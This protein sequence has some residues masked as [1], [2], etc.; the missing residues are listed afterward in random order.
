MQ[1]GDGIGR[2]SDVDEFFFSSRRRHTR[3]TGD[4]SS[5]VC[6]SDLLILLAAAA[7]LA[8]ELVRRAERLRRLASIDRVTGLQNR[9]F[10]D[11]RMSVELER[12]R[13]HGHDLALVLL[14]VD[15]F[16]AFNERFGRAAGDAALRAFGGM[17]RAGAPPGSSLGRYGNDEFVLLLPG[18]SAEEAGARVEAI[19]GEVGRQ[20]VRLPGGRE[21]GRPGF[22]AG[23]ATFPADGREAGPL[24]LRAE[25]RLHAARVGA[26][27]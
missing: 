4:W 20:R 7:G 9:A 5:D 3:W 25:A 6:S 24:L 8:W 16:R 11:T 15:G 26:R 14:D 21:V 27:G 22:T 23:I 17:L 10:F 13:A 18:S 1:D 12:A 2:A 19:R